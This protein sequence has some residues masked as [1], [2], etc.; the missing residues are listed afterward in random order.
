M[1]KKNL[2]IIPF[3]NSS[4][5][6]PWIFDDADRSFDV[7]LHYYHKSITNT[8]LKIEGTS[9]KLYH[10]CNF[11]WI[12]AYD[13]F[14][15]N[16]DYLNRYEYFFFPDDDIEIKKETIHLLFELMKVSNLQMTQPVLLPGSFKS[17]KA[18][19]KKRW[20]GI[21]YLSTVELMCPA[22]SKNAIVELLPTFNL[23]KSGWGIDILWGEMIRKKFGPMS[24]AVFDVVAAKHTKPVGKGELYDKIGKSA[25]EER[26]EIFEKYNITKRKIYNLPLIENQ[27]LNR[28][29]SYIYLKKRFL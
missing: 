14:I 6:S 13:F 23:N 11:K 1:L 22:L 8:Q 5:E 26:D 20:S 16:P 19:K 2:V 24:I 29:K 3:G 27:I 10:L 25:F 9:F 15:Q 28:I 12:M 18:L 17:W 4:I 21:R 7:V